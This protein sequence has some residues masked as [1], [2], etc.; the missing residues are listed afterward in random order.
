MT[1]RHGNESPCERCRVSDRVR[2]RCAAVEPKPA[3]APPSG[4]LRIIIQ[5]IR[6]DRCEHLGKR[7]EF[8]QGCNGFN[9][10]HEC[11]KGMPAVP[12]KLC[13]TCPLYEAVTGEAWLS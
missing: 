5:I 8:R 10:Q 7:T 12:G 9:C 4:P 13:Q 11:A 3:T 2:E 6:P 1:C